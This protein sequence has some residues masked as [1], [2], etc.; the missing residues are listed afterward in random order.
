[1]EHK[2]NNCIEASNEIIPTEKSFKMKLLLLDLRIG[3]GILLM[4]MSMIIQGVLVVAFPFPSMSRSRSLLLHP[5]SHGYVLSSSSTSSKVVMRAHRGR[6]DKGVK[7]RKKKV[8][9]GN[10]SKASPSS[11][12]ELDDDLSRTRRIHSN[13]TMINGV[14]RSE[15][16]YVRDS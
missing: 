13:D 6:R 5:S 16:K 10:K 1:M 7:T 3:I 14:V 4:S 9:H 12:R 15:G 2:S 11:S 8:K